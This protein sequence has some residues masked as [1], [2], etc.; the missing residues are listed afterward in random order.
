MTRMGTSSEA[1]TLDEVYQA[2][3]RSDRSWLEATLLDRW[4]RHSSS[5][6]TVLGLHDVTSPT[7]G[8]SHELSEHL[9]RFRNHDWPSTELGPLQS[10]PHALRQWVNVMMADPRAVALWWGR[11]RLCLYNDAYRDILGKRHS[12]ALSKPLTSVWP[13]EDPNT[14]RLREA[15]NHADATGQPTFGG[16]TCFFVDRSGF[17]EEVWTSWALIPIMGPSENIAYFNPCSETTKQ[18]LYDR[19]MATLLAVERASNEATNLKDWYRS[20]LIGLESNSADIP[21][22]ALYSMSSRS[23]ARDHSALGSLNGTPI[24]ASVAFASSQWTLEGVLEMESNTLGLP[25]AMDWD[26]ATE[27]F[28]PMAWRFDRHKR[29][30]IP[31][32]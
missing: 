12:W 4:Q 20:V 2:L 7:F 6:S 15:F 16:D 28:G 11:N 29:R 23:S 18:V 25:T 13:D 21:F 1:Q 26:L 27:T 9:T 30:A 31:Q 10:W 17:K 22:A 19:R 8:A 3:K 14:A 5:E 24:S 32:C